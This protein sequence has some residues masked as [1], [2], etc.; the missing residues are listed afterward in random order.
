MK[1]GIIV[2]AALAACLMFSTGKADAQS[3]EDFKAYKERTMSQ[4]NTYKK[5]VQTEFKAYRE[6]VNAEFEGGKHQRRV[7]MINALEIR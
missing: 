3:M 6:R 7:D 4:F 1:S 5:Q 2:V